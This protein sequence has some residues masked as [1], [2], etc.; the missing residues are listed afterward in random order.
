M[1][2]ITV[3]DSTRMVNTKGR[4]NLRTGKERRLDMESHHDEMI[5]EKPSKAAV[6]CFKR[7]PYSI[8]GDTGGQV[9]LNRV[10][11]YERRN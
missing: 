3:D 7:K 4:D 8:R 9:N 6:E 10:Q 1:N 5:K 11:E 2:A